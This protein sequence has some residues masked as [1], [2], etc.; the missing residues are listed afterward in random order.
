[1]YQVRLIYIKFT[2][3]GFK[4]SCRITRQSPSLA[5]EHVFWHD[6]LI[7]KRRAF[8]IYYMKVNK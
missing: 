8:D 5:I 4:K 1:M 7:I 3:L 6:K 2:K